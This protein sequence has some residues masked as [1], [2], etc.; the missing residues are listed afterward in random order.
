MWLDHWA[1][2]DEPAF[3]DCNMVVAEL[4]TLHGNCYSG[5]SIADNAHAH[6]LNGILAEGASS[7]LGV[8]GDASLQQTIEIRSQIGYLKAILLPTAF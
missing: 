5:V 3:P 6:L 2:E 1:R 8:G 4:S 7:L